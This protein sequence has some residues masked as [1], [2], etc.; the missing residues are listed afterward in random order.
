MVK[1]G[2]LWALAIVSGAF[3]VEGSAAAAGPQPHWSDGLTTASGEP[4]AWLPSCAPELAKLGLRRCFS[5]RLVPESVAVDRLLRVHDAVTRL[6]PLKKS[7]CGTANGPG[8]GGPVDAGPLPIGLG[9]DGLQKAYSLL[10]SGLPDGSGAVVGIVDACANATV[11]SDLAAYRTQY[12]LPALPECG[13]ANGVAPTKGGTACI[14]VVSQT[15]TS[16]LPANDDNWAGEIALDVDMVSAACPKC[17][18]L[19]VEANDA[20]DSDLSTAVDY[21]AAHAD[22]V[23]NS[24]GSSESGGDSDTAYNHAG[25]L[26]AAA[27]G[28]ADWYN[29][30]DL[31]TT[32]AD[33]EA[34]TVAYTPVAANTPAS[35]PTV[36][37]VGGSMVMDDAAAARGYSDNVW[38]FE[39][40][41]PD[42][43]SLLNKVVYG[44]GSGCSKEFAKPSFQSGIST[45]TC[46]MRDSVDLSGPSDYT[47]VPAV[48]KAGGILSYAEGS[49]GQVVGTSAASPFVTALLTRLG[50][51]SQSI[52]TLYGKSGDFND[53]TTGNNDPSGTCPN[54]IDCN[55]APGWDG[56]TGLGTPNAALLAGV[57]GGTIA[58]PE[59]AGSSTDS[60]AGSSSG[61]GSGS[62][63]GGGSGSSSGSSSGGGSGSSSGSVSDDSGVASSGS[64][65]GSGSSSGGFISDDAGNTVDLDGAPGNGAGSGGS[66]SNGCSCTQVGSGDGSPLAPGMLSIVGL[67]AIFALRGRRRR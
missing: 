48:K 6:L 3:F 15:G 24:Y 52:A 9:A 64:G 39:A 51:A 54:T 21:A 66:S 56:P 26:I 30:V 8:G 2:S 58:T 14:G 7:S 1:I 44:G 47:P 60:G 27:S 4:M 45:G 61:G 46:T 31:N 20:D 34:W 36:L 18:I 13:G 29:Q 10:A 22:S 65:G 43:P 55:A 32:A 16:T 38:S 19:L 5:S 25:I 67:G 62:S 41:N 35:M 28:D 42:L 37:A 63:S 57:D 11:V 33:A 49:W 50:Y 23:S 59:D 17:S 53:V 40:T 12:G